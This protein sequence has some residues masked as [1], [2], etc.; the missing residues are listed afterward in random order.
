MP[1][2][3]ES[4]LLNPQLFDWRREPVLREARRWLLND[5]NPETVPELIAI[6]SEGPAVLD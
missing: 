3:F 6:V 2:R 1:T 4:G 5:F